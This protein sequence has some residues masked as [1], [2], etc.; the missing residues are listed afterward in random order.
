M[1]IRCARF[2]VGDVLIVP[3]IMAVSLCDRVMVLAGLAN[4][5]VKTLVN[6]GLPSL[7][8]SGFC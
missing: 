1:C 5:S 6:A 7:K 3:F 4:G 8:I 2:R